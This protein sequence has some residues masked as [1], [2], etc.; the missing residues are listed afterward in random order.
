MDP[1]G[2]REREGKEDSCFLFFP[3]R[4][5]VWVPAGSRRLI[6]MARRLRFSFRS[7]CLFPPK[8]R[9]RGAGALAGPGQSPLRAPPGRGQGRGGAALAGPPAAVTRQRSG[10]APAAR[11]PIRGVCCPGAR[12]PETPGRARPHGSGLAPRAHPHRPSWPISGRACAARR[13]ARA[14]A[15][16]VRPP[17]HAAT[18]RAPLPHAHPGARVQLSSPATASAPA[19]PPTPAGRGGGGP[20]TPTP[21]PTAPRPQS[22]QAP[23]GARLK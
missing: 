10:A 1:S 2:G 15:S 22:V 4:N 16:R 12:A 5:P 20:G 19:P 13:L 23:E 3:P 17:P 18:A 6:S 14:R 11:R 8:N 9:A 21:P 7:L